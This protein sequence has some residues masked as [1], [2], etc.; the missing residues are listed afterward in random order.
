M[1]LVTGIAVTL[2][3][4]TGVHQRDIARSAGA[5][6][7]DSLT[8]GGPPRILVLPIII[9]DAQATD[10]HRALAGGV[11]E[12]IIRALSRLPGLRVLGR[13]TSLAAASSN[14]GN[15]TLRDAHSVRYVV[16]G[17]F[18]MLG[19]HFQLRVGLLDTAT[20]E[21]I[22]SERLSGPMSQVVDLGEQVVEKLASQT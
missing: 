5:P 10:R 12:D 13:Q 18:E 8:S 1:I 2:Y 11:S 19:D 20:G 16:S 21:T 22:W 6:N 15:A 9:N 3:G 4:A 14:I 7:G 17:G